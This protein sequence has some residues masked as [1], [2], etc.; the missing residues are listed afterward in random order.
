[1]STFPLEN[2]DSQTAFLSK[3]AKFSKLNNVLD[4]PPS[5]VDG[6]LSRD[7]WIFS[8]QLSRLI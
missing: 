3:L 6:F 8:I 7:K 5:K 1:L 2:P 4:A